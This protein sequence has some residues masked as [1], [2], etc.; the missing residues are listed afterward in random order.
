MIIRTF[1]EDYYMFI[2]SKFQTII[3]FG[4]QDF[5]IRINTELT[6]F[7]NKC[8]HLYRVFIHFIFYKSMLHFRCFN[9]NYIR[10]LLNYCKYSLKLYLHRISAN[11]LLL[12]MIYGILNKHDQ[13][14]FKYINKFKFISC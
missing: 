13:N 11:Y 1:V 4:S 6:V 5:L 10:N 3:S 14:Q 8:Y 9:F 2:L 12:E 7:K